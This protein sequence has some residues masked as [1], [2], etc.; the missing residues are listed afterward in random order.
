MQRS[1]V[2]VAVSI[3][4]TPQDRTLLTIKQRLEGSYWANNEGV[5]QIQFLSDDA[6]LTNLLTP[7]QFQVLRFTPDIVAYQAFQTVIPGR[8]NND[9]SVEYGGGRLGMLTNKGIEWVDGAVW[10][11]VRFV[12][13]APVDLLDLQSIQ[14]QAYLDSKVVMDDI[15]A[16]HYL[17]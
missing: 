6:P 2:P 7:H 12:P 3:L 4:T 11:P 9:G 14:R 15:Y 8:L 16:G 1:H 10:A 17:Y 13:P 5:F